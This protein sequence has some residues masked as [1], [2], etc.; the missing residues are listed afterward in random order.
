MHEVAPRQLVE[1]KLFEIAENRRNIKLEDETLQ[2][3]TVENEA[4]L[5]VVPLHLLDL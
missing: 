2:P 3:S 5:R 1:A 4:K